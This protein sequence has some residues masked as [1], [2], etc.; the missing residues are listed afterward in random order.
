MK[1]RQVNKTVLIQC[2]G[3]T[4]KHYI[5]EIKLSNEFRNITIRPDIGGRTDPLGVIEAAIRGYE[6]NN[7]DKVYILIDYDKPDEVKK[8]SGASGE[9][10]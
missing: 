5:N 9:L 1:K 4:E 10:H 7:Y 2:E 3:L 6:S 8:S